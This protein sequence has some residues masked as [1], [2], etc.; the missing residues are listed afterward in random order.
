MPAPGPERTWQLVIPVRGTAPSK[1]RLALPDSARERLAR[2]FARDTVRAAVEASTVA[3]VIV[4]TAEPARE[5]FEAM[6]ARVVSDPQPPSL[7]TAIARGLAACDP[8]APR[9]VMLGDLPA[10][11]G[12]ALDEALKAAGRLD[13]AVVPDADGTGTTL[14]TAA[15]RVPHSPAFGTGSFARHLA[16][17]Y[18]SVADAVPD[19]VRSDVDTLDD[20]ARAASLGL[21]ASS[22]R[23][24]AAINAPVGATTRR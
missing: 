11:T 16:A 4:V 23:A 15:A 14:V 20:L 7:A 10:L 12:A 5:V 1:S 19:R 18:V 2:A 13:R 17:G 6:G 24:C 8:D 22:R 3:R 21:G 9:A